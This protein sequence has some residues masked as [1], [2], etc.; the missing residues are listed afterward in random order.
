MSYWMNVR[1]IKTR[2][3]YESA[4]DKKFFLDSHCDSNYYYLSNRSIYLSVETRKRIRLINIADSSCRHC[5]SN[6]LCKLVISILKYMEYWPL[7]Y[8]LRLL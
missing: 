3:V 8:L 7:E 1:V 2:V 4:G 6:L 5:L